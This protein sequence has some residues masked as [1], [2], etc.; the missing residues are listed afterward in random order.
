MR[1]VFGLVCMTYAE[2]VIQTDGK[3]REMCHDHYTM[4][5]AFNCCGFHPKL[6]EFASSGLYISN[7]TLHGGYCSTKVS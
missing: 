4:A 1:R 6:D 5:E 3:I 7:L 2:T